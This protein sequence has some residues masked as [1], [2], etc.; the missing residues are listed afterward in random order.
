[1]NSKSPVIDRLTGRGLQRRMILFAAVA[2]TACLGEPARS[3]GVVGEATIDLRGLR[4]L[5]QVANDTTDEVQS[6]RFAVLS[7]SGSTR[8]EVASRLFGLNGTNAQD[9]DSG[10]VFRMSFPYS[11]VTD[12]FELLGYGFSA[13]GDSL[14]RVGPQ[15]FSMSTA[16]NK[17][18]AAMV[19]V[20]AVPV[21]VG[22]GRTATKLT[23]SPRSVTTEQG[24]STALSATLTDA[25]GKVL[26]SPTFRLEW[27]SMNGGI[28]FFKNSRVGIVYGANQPGSTFIMARFDPMNLIDSVRV[29]NTVPPGQMKVINGNNQTGRVNATLPTPITVQVFGANGGFGLAGVPVSFVVTQ[30]GGS[31]NFASRTTSSPDGVAQVNWT[32]GPTSGLQVLTIGVAGLSN[33]TVTASAIP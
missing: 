15:L 8:R 13:Q 1:M 24:K 14:Y 3:R 16:V 17:D 19:T 20:A 2:L 31:V 29:T 27:H 4:S 23:I 7:V 25:A 22:P 33:I 21:Y 11:S 32:M 6:A 28:A 18:G 9:T 5:N 30:G 12:Q 26:S 10:S